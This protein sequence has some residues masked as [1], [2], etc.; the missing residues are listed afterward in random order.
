MMRRV[1]NF[2]ID[3]A[4]QPLADTMARWVS[5]YGIAAFMLTGVFLAKASDYVVNR[6]Y[7]PLVLMLIYLPF[8]T[9]RAYQLDA[10]PERSVLPPERA[11]MF[12]FRMFSLLTNP[13]DVLA[14]AMAV[15][16]WDRIRFGAWLLLT[17]ALYFMA[18]R[19][20]PPKPRRA[21][22]PAAVAETV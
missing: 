7:F 4:F 8:V 17:P 14:V 10:E 9:L 18:C 13:L 5:C 1:D 12:W 19:R 20:N 15:N 2:L 11:T 3:R 22:V 21:V 6:D 16:W